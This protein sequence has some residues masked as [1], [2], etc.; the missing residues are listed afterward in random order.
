MVHALHQG[1]LQLAPLGAYTICPHCPKSASGAPRIWS[2]VR[3]RLPAPLAL[4]L[5]CFLLVSLTSV[6]NPSLSLHNIPSSHV[7]LTS[8]LN[9]SSPSELDCYSTSSGS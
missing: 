4:A 7:L 5:G 9:S 6:L 8:V 2:P 3:M 1:V